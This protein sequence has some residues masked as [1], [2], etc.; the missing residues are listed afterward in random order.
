M[1]HEHIVSIFLENTDTSTV[2]LLLTNTSF[3][4]DP[5]SSLENLKFGDS[6]YPLL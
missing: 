3:I 2:V 1:L 6:L 4:I 5:T